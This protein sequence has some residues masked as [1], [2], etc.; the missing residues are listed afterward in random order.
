MVVVD[1][2]VEMIFCVVA[3]AVEVIWTVA[4]ASVAEVEIVVVL[5]LVG[6]TSPFS[7]FLMRTSRIAVEFRRLNLRTFLGKNKGL[8]MPEA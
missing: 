7:S 3:S 2:I 6:A 8:R 5:L 1:A 4:D